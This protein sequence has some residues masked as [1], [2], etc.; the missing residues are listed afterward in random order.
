MYIKRNKALKKMGYSS[1]KE[2]L[3]SDEWRM[4]K[5]RFRKKKGSNRCFVCGTSGNLQVHHNKYHAK[6]MKNGTTGNLIALCGE[7]HKEVH[8]LATRMGWPFKKSVHSLFKRYKKYGDIHYY[9][10]KT[11]IKVPIQ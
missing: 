10:P 1:Y 5:E 9:P 11:S 7:C 3:S 8:L 2:Y 4:V 6:P